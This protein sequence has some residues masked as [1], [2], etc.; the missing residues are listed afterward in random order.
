MKRFVKITTTLALAA[1][2][3]LAAQQA[4]A[5]AIKVTDGVTT[6]IATDV[7]NDGIVSFVGSVGAWFINSVLGIANPATGDEF[8]DVMHL[9]SVDVSNGAG[10]LTVMLTDTDMSKTNAPFMTTLGGA[11]GGSVS[12]ATYMSSTNTAFDL[13]TL[14]DSSGTFSG[15]GFSQNGSGGIST[16]GPYSLTQVVT[17]THGG[18]LRS[19][20]FDYEIK[21][22]EAVPEPMTL[23]LVGAGLAGMGVFGRRKRNA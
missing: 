12:F 3:M 1:S 6:A 16:S 23:T 10:T 21:V 19:T 13:E 11:T 14:L 18:G 5:L 20:S 4:K 17:I 9:N 2:S 7:D 8:T 22:P 15:G